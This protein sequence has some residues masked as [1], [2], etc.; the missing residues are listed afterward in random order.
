MIMRKAKK[1]P[2]SKNAGFSLVELLIAVTI[3]AIIVIP[4]LHMFVTSARMNG[5]A[6]QTLRATTVAQNLMEGLKAYDIEELQTQFNAPAD[7][8]Y[9]MDSR[10][11]HGAIGEDTA[12]EQPG[13]YYFTLAD[14]QLQGSE[15]DALIKIDATGYETGNLTSDAADPSD[16]N[17]HHDN[18]MNGGYIATPGSVNDGK[19]GGI[20]DGYFT[21]TNQA[22]LEELRKTYNDDSITTRDFKNMGGKYS[23]KITLE[24]MAGLPDEEG[25]PTF[26]AYYWSEY[27]FDYNGIHGELY[28]QGNPNI[29]ETGDFLDFSTENCYLFYY[30]LYGA[31][32][33]EIIIK[34]D[35]NQPLRLYL[36]K[37]IAGEDSDDKLSDS[38]LDAAERSYHVKVDIQDS[39]KENVK[40]R[41]NLGLNIV[42]AAF[43][44][45]LTPIAGQLP[46]VDVEK[47]DLPTQVSYYY[48]G[49]ADGAMN[50]FSL[51]GIRYKAYGTGTNDEITEVIYDIEVSIYKEGAY[52]A[53]FPESERMAVITGSKN[54]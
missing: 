45:G 1:Q 30:P 2:N 17:P 33:E 40:I 37:Q 12:R 23:R 26:D 28:P 14:V 39:K 21:L 22:F 52:A 43:K 42:N 6:K 25:N 24:L 54:N 19:G 51:S 46:T 11:I 7:G 53:G 50:V 13:I 49:A 9:V 5:K 29:G 16:G 48:N 34:N 35:A 20:K 31:D 8:F 32:S 3:L 15:Y 10:L 41:T 18:A 47:P 36:V 38:Q 44:G 4:M 27:T